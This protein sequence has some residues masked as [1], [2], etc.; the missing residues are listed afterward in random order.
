MRNWNKQAISEGMK[1]I[2]IASLP[3]RNWNKRNWWI[4]PVYTKIASLPMRNWN[5]QTLTREGLGPAHC[6]PTYEELKLQCISGQFD[7]C[8]IAS[9]PM[10][11]WNQ[12][13]NFNPLFLFFGLRAYLW[14]IEILCFASNSLGVHSLRAYLWGIEIN[15]YLHHTR[16]QPRRLRAY[17]WGIEIKGSASPIWAKKELRAYLWGIEIF[18][19]I[20][21]IVTL[22]RIASLPMRNWNLTV[23]PHIQNII[24]NCEPTYEELKCF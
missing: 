15:Y 21:L 12:L 1:E 4:F 11:N 6:E 24:Q 9:L 2:R 19:Y 18:I 17:L 22:F 8:W 20:C 13:Q 3:M 16:P 7:F 23:R 14:G 10:R 5:A